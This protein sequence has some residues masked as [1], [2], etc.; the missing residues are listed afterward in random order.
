MV[1]LNKPWGVG[2]IPKQVDNWAEGSLL[3]PHNGVKGVHPARRAV[4]IH[5]LELIE[6][7]ANVDYFF[8]PAH[9]AS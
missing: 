9:I 7:E 6:I 5:F 4:D 2:S 8:D 3:V 1:I